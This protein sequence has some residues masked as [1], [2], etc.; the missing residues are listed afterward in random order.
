MG[1]CVSGSTK[2]KPS[3]DM[4]GIH[5]FNKRALLIQNRKTTEDARRKIFKIKDENAPSLDISKNKLYLNRIQTKSPEGLN[6]TQFVYK[7]P[8]NYN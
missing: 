3:F 2:L 8:L 7:N 4:S 5:K 6:K 1:S